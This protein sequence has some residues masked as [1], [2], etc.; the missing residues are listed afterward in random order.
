MITGCSKDDESSMPTNSSI[1][2]DELVEYIGKSPQYVK[3]NFK[4]G[5]LVD[6]G[7]TLGRTDLTY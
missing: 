2:V 1:G 3:D 7:G 6:E 5:K 4:D